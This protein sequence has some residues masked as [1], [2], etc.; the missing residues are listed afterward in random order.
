MLKAI[1]KSL[2]EDPAWTA[3]QLNKASSLGGVSIRVIQH[4]CL[5]KLKL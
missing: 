2:A 5:K 1:K 4:T 3:K